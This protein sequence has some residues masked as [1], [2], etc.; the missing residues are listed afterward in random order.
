MYPFLLSNR[1]IS[2]LQN[3]FACLVL[4]LSV[5][6]VGAEAQQATATISNL[7][8][9]VTV[10]FQGNETSAA[11]QGTVLQAGDIIETGAGSAVVLLLSEGSELRLGPKSK[12]DLTILAHHPKSKARQSR[13][14]LLYGRLRAFL[15]PGHQ[16]ADSSFTV[17]TPNAVAGVKFSRPEIEFLY[18]PKAIISYITTYASDVQVENLQTRE[19]KLISAGTQAIVQGDEIRIIA[20][21]QVDK[22]SLSPRKEEEGSPQLP[23]RTKKKD[24]LLQSQQ[25]LSMAA[26]GS[27]PIAV[28]VDSPKD[29]TPV[30]SS[31]P[32][33]GETS[34]PPAKRYDYRTITINIDNK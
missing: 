12:L 22:N 16:K 28:R 4:L 27:V 15:S 10:T 20:L 31:V 1:G 29:S 11:A 33:P 6:S 7:S 23:S 13:M 17:E 9:T 30:T 26:S 5:W 2:H 25:A 3:V 34:S 24:L 21:S 14:K 32:S 18:D 19:T 8:G